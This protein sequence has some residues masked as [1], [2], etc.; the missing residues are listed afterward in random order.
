MGVVVG[1]D[2]VVDVVVGAFDE[3]LR[4]LLH[5]SQGACVGVCVCVCVCVWFC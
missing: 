5:L 3:N 4:G 2:M 1:V